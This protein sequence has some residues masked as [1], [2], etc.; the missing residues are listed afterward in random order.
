MRFVGRDI[1]AEEGRPICPKQRLNLVVSWLGVWLV[2][3]VFGWLFCWVTAS[4]V[5]AWLVVWFVE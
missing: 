5:V 2:S 1:L 4:M 3:W